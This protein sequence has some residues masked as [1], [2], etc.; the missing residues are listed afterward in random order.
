MSKE[1]I[2]AWYLQRGKTDRCEDHLDQIAVVYYA[3]NETT[4]LNSVTV[5]TPRKT[6]TAQRQLQQWWR[7]L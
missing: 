7:Y 4:Q 6:L 2:D 3:D 5:G 1:Q